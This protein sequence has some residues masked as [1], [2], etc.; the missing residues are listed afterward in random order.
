MIGHE[1]N[2]GNKMGTV[3]P[4][5]GDHGTVFDFET[6]DEAMLPFGRWLSCFSFDVVEEG[7]STDAGRT[8]FALRLG[9]RTVALVRLARGASSAIAA[10]IRASLTAAVSS[11]S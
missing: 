8:V 4:L 6:A 5:S 11:T 9:G 1:A 2:A 7:R 10:A 3:A